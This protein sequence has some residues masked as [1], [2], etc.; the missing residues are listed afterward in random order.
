MSVLNNFRRNLISR[1]LSKSAKSTKFSSSENFF[2]KGFVG[3]VAMSVEQ[4]LEF[5]SIYISR[6]CFTST[7]IIIIIIIVFVFAI[8]IFS[9]NLWEVLWQIVSGVERFPINKAAFLPFTFSKKDVSDLLA[10]FSAFLFFLYIFSWDFPN[11]VEPRLRHSTSR[12]HY[13]YYSTSLRWHLSLYALSV[14]SYRQ[15]YFLTFS[16]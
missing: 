4:I 12:H 15:E 9:V 8:V 13:L 5:C 16:N 14:L 2:P 3:F 7:T 10:F 6:T 1:I 11:T